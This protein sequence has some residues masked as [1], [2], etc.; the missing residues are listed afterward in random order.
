MKCKIIYLSLT[1]NT[2]RAAERVKE[3]IVNSGHECELLEMRDFTNNSEFSGFDLFGF[4]APVHAFGV[5]TIY[6]RFLRNLTRINSTYSFIGATAATNFGS[7]YSNI[8]KI[9][10]EKGFTS[11]AKL[12]VYA[13]PSFTPWNPAGDKEHAYKETELKMAYNF[14]MNIF[15]EYNEIVVKKSKNPPKFTQNIGSSLFSMIANSDTSLR[16]LLGSI[17]I[18]KDACTKCGICVDNCAWNAIKIDSQTSFPKRIKETCGG[19]CACIN[20]CPEGALWN[21]K[22]KGKV[23]YREPNYKGYNKKVGIK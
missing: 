22:T 4:M 18:T 3:G 14:G 23:L 13:P 21:T 8:N 5:P 10:I 16:M 20:L 7:F 2:K 9:L 15:N 19:C 1:G 17:K 12:S 6:S 11:F